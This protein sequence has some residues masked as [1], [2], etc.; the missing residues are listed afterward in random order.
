MSTAGSRVDEDG[1]PPAKTS[2]G[3]EP[4]KGGK[5]REGPLTSQGDRPRQLHELPEPPWS[6]CDR[7]TV[8]PLSIRTPVR[9]A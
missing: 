1:R 7:P 4:G 6:R 5:D 3:K 2:S 9:L 8:H